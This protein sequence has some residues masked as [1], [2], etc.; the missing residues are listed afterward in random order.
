MEGDI[1][2][3]ELD[4]LYRMEEYTSAGLPLGDLSLLYL[5]IRKNLFGNDL[6]IAEQGSTS[7][8]EKYIELFPTKEILITEFQISSIEEYIS[9]LAIFSSHFDYDTKVLGLYLLDKDYNLLLDSGKFRSIYEQGEIDTPLNGLKASLR[10]RSK[11]KY[12]L[13]I[14]SV[15]EMLD[16]LKIPVSHVLSNATVKNIINRNDELLFS[17][18]VN[19]ERLDDIPPYFEDIRV[20]KNLY[21]TSYNNKID[22]RPLVYIAN[23]YDPNF[24]LDVQYDIEENAINV[25]EYVYSDAQGL[26]YNAILNNDLVPAFIIA[27]D[28]IGRNL[29]YRPNYDSVSILKKRIDEE[30]SWD[31]EGSIVSG[32]KELLEI[33][34]Y[35]NAEYY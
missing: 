2:T 35:M 15:D 9:D 31:S 17:H 4:L 18:K 8:L 22:Y 28:I 29:P 3:N 11:L 24:L 23:K 6:P 7:I 20:V 27:D 5:H 16:K 26:L 30:D 32:Y 33:I 14:D 13:M 10:F 21:P 25:I 12:K 1:N 34:E 19:M